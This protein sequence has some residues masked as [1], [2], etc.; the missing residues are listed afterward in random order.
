MSHHEHVV[1]AALADGTGFDLVGDLKASEFTEPVLADWYARMAGQAIAGKPYDIVTLLD[2]DDGFDLSTAN[3]VVKNYQHFHRSLEAA[4][5]AIKAGAMRRKLLA[6]AKEMHS[7]AESNESPE[8][9]R[10][11]FETALAGVETGQQHAISLKKAISGA[12]AEIERREKGDTGVKTGIASIDDIAVG[13]RAGELVVIAARPGMGKTALALNISAS[14]ARHH[15][16]VLIMSAEMQSDELATRMMSSGSG[17]SYGD[18]RRARLE[19]G[20]YDLMMNWVATHRDLPVYIDDR[21][22]PTIAQVASEAKRIKR[23]HGLSMLVV[24][25][26]G[27][28]HGVGNSRTEEVGSVS[29]ALKGLAKDLKCPVIALHQLSRKCDERT[30][31]RPLTS[32]LRDSGEIE[33]DADVVAMLYRDSQ[34]DKKS[35]YGNLAELIFRKSRG[36]AGDTAWLEWD[37]SRQRFTTASEPQFDEQQKSGGYRYV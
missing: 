4:V 2:L 27:L 12:V 20:D 19:S 13:M 22:G 17:A 14:V 21:S 7:L 3:S 8:E 23:L 10:A 35:K 1:C 9:I 26:L 11:K 29:R 25:Y 34:Y 15:G 16:P 18:M 28:V 31:K 36:F 24:D 37:G 5:K 32:D 33:Q 30:D 6:I